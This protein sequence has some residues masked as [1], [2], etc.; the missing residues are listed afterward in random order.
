[1]DFTI[2]TPE[3]QRIRDPHAK[4][5]PEIA[6]S[7]SLLARKVETIV[8]HGHFPLVIGGDHS[9][10]MG[11]IAGISASARKRKK[12]I[13]VFWV[14]AHGDFNTPASSPSGNIHGMPLAV[15]CGLGPHQ[16]TSIGGDFR[17]VD[18]KN[19]VIIGLRNLDKA[20]R[21]NLKKFGVKIF[22]M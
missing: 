5:L 3:E 11:T 9:I 14:D 19:V 15:C 10:A 6:R 21:E 4:Y 22:T 12:K 20:E 13:G 16:L 8:N 17:K 7:C 1:G 2:K 18:P